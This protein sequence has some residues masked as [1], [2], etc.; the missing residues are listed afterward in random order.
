M[1]SEGGFENRLPAEDMLHRM[2]IEPEKNE[3]LDI[4][5]DSNGQPRLKKGG[6]PIVGAVIPKGGK[7]TSGKDLDSM[8]HSIMSS[9]GNSEKENKEM[10]A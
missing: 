3:T 6:K 7:I 9:T 10:V 1:I 8:N 5:L 2:I 4:S